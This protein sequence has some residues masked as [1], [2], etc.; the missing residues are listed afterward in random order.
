[1]YS[2]GSMRVLLT[3]VAGFM[4]SHVLEHLLKNTDW[5]VV[6][7][8]SWKH[9]GTPERVEEVLSTDTSWRERV[10]IIT[11]DLSAPFTD[12]TKQR[13]P[14]ID[15]IINVAS[16]S[17][18]DRS[19]YDP[20]PF[21]QNNVNLMLTMLELAR[22]IKP[23]KFLQVSTDEV[24]GPAPDNVLHKEWSTVLPSNPY[25]ASKAMQEALCISYWRTYNVPL[26]IT[27]SMNLFGPM[28][29]P[30]KYIAQLIRKI[31]KGETVTVHGSE[32][33]VGSRFYLNARNQA[34]A[35]L[36]I[37]KNV[38][39]VSFS[40]EGNID[41]PLRFNIV[42]ETEMDNL[43][44]AKLVA[45]MMGKELKYAFIDFHATRP[46]H[47]RRYALDGALLKSLGWKPPH[48]FEYS[49]Q[50]TIDWTLKHPQWL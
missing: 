3:G 38:A 2:S 22:E 11:H 49:L 26:I 44:L 39:P 47:D 10:T 9:K 19:I 45:K 36:F 24:Y 29:D 40:D 21:V 33:K 46:G 4:G 32:E 27:N 17:H 35:L 28:Q 13:L 16:D 12:H 31:Y 43:S 14:H 48:P 15:Y 1:M 50:T 30:E 42:G 34:D 8:A 7:I 6:G 41:R 20:V 5:D 23:H 25:S 37:L 18:V